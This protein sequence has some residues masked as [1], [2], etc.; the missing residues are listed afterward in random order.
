MT[1]SHLWLLTGVLLIVFEAFG[2]SGIGLSFAGLGALT[3]G[4][5]IE[6]GAIAE[7]ATVT[8][9]AVC[10]ISAAIWALLLWNALKKFKK[11][12]SRYSN[13]I[14]DTAYVGS[15]GLQKGIVGEVTWS[16]T[17]MRAELAKHSPVAVLEAGAQV[18]IVELIGAKLVVKPKE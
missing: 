6:A 18:T 7:G 13:I 5:L 15:S 14:G 16:G 4:G 8:Q 12:G 3:A 9:F 10:V 11:H 1:P 17:I 2:L